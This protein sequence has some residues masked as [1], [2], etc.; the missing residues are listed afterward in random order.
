MCSDREASINALLSSITTSKLVK[1]CKIGLKVKILR[2]LITFFWVPGHSK[3]EGNK[4]A[5]EL[6][7]LGSTSEVY[8]SNRICAEK[9]AIIY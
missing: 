2:N 8:G 9:E 3:V 6:T 4:R 5:D 1:D 7:R